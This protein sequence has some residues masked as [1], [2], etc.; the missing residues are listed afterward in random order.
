MAT[1]SPSQRIQRAQAQVHRALAEW[2]GADLAR[3]NQCRE[4]L[5]AAASDLREASG[6]LAASRGYLPIDARRALMD[7]KC[8]AR[9]MTHVVDA[10]A[11]LA[12]GLA[13]R[14]GV[15]DPNYDAQGLATEPGSRPREVVFDA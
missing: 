7:L 2:N 13:L 6:E 11:A 15:A 9:R 14:L 4:L 8:D 1:P 10:C 12:R 5:A 3:A